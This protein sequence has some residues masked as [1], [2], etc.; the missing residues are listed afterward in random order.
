MSQGVGEIVANLDA[1]DAMDEVAAVMTPAAA[2]K[3]LAA[4]NETRRL[5]SYNVSP[6]LAMEAMLFDVREV[7]R[8]P[9]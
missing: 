6:Q 7:L 9:R 2:V 3:A 4:V 8:C 1:L 5:I